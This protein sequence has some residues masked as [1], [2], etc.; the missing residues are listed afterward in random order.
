VSW[1]CGQQQLDCGFPGKQGGSDPSVTADAAVAFTAAGVDPAQV[2]RD[3][4]SIIDFL[5]PSAGMY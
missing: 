4:H 3:G 2:K 5:S 1:L